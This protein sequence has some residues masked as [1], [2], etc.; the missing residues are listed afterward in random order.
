MK[1]KLIMENWRGYMKENEEAA[2]YGDLYLFEG[3]EVSKTSFY[4]AINML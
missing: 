1:H 2:L 3:D 4:E